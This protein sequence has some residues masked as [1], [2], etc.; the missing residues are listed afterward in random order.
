MSATI[1]EIETREHLDELIERS[2]DRPVLIFKHSATCPISSH[3]LSEVR[4]IDAELNLVVV[5]R[6]QWLSNDI[7]SRLGIMH[8]S[9]QAIVVRNGSAIYNA[10]HYD[11]SGDDIAD[12][13]K[14]WDAE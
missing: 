6:S 7:E 11:V 5:Q 14:P 9:P 8:E 1:T 4:G 13:L 12:V 2:C 3:V 10:S